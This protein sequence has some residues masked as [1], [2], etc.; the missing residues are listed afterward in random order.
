LNFTD[1]ITVVFGVLTLAL[2][3]LCIDAMM[4][5]LQRTASFRGSR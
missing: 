2:V 4:G 3:Y 5:Y 1:A